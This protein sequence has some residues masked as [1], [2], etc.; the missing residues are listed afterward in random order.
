MVAARGHIETIQGIDALIGVAE[1]EA[2]K[3]I[4]QG[5]PSHRPPHLNRKKVRMIV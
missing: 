4:R 1:A 2:I 3:A 5:D